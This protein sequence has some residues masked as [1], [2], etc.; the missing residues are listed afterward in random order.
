DGGVKAAL[1]PGGCPGRTEVAQGIG[2]PGGIA[3]YPPDFATIKSGLHRILSHDPA[4]EQGLAG[5]RP[6]SEQDAIA[7]NPLPRDAVQSLVVRS[8]TSG[9]PRPVCSSRTW[10][11]KQLD[12]SP[13]VNRARTVS[14]QTMFIQGRGS[15]NSLADGPPARPDLTVRRG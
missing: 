15:H 2:G 14:R 5:G 11:A 8:S 4:V 6:Q 7:V 1:P 12:G 10:M 3:P 13:V 9:T